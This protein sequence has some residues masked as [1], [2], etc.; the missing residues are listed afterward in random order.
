MA[1][2]ALFME[3]LAWGSV[4]LVLAIVL[5]VVLYLS[6]KRAYP[7]ST[8]ATR[9]YRISSTLAPLLGLLW[10]L[11]SLI[12]HVIIS[13]YLAHQSVGFSPDPYVTLPNGFRLGSHN[14]YDG[15]I[16]APGYDTDVPVTGPGYVRSIIDV[17]WVGRT[18]R[19]SLFDFHS[20]SMQNFVFNTKTLHIETSP[21]GPT[22]WEA[23]NDKAQLGPQ[24]YW[25]LYRQYR[26][27]WPTYV[28]LGILILGEALIIWT[29]VFLRRK[30]IDGLRAPGGEAARER[31]AL[32]VESNRK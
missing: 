22:T 24:S 25:L 20:S 14:T 16:V 23:A 26:H 27:I 4:L 18:F 32:A 8:A 17:A 19:G 11:A 9:T 15:Y 28:F 7:E 3:F 2:F 6:A 30:A 29:I 13:N 5:S 31:A 10:L 1:G 12:L 21:V